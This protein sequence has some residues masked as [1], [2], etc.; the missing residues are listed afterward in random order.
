MQLPGR[1][2]HVVASA[3]EHFE[4]CLGNIRQIAGMM[5]E[6]GETLDHE[7]RRDYLRAIERKAGHLLDINT[8]LGDFAQVAFGGKPISRARLRLS[9]VAAQ[10]I[11][12]LTPLAAGS[13]RML[14]LAQAAGEPLIAGDYRKLLNALLGI[15]RHSIAIAAPAAQILVNIR[16]A[17]NELRLE[18]E[19]P[20]APKSRAPETESRPLSEP[21]LAAGSGLTT[22]VVAQIIELHGGRLDILS[23]ETHHRFTIALPISGES[24]DDFSSAN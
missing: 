7:Q 10:A 5:L 6:H 14:V 22:A 13:R 17:V 16:P 23:D 24:F 1:A 19:V 2:F 20:A 4:I 15:L 12:A 21:P 18:I 8:H 9:D 3:S 11:D